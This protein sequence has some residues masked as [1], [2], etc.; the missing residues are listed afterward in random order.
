MLLL[1]K[2]IDFNIGSGSGA[3][4]SEPLIGLHRSHGRGFGRGLGADS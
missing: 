1:S 4:Y 3:D 2:V